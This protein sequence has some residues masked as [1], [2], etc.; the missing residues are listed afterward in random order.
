MNTSEHARKSSLVFIFDS[1]AE[2]QKFRAL[3]IV[4]DFSREALA[5]VPDFSV[6]G[7]RVVRELDRLVSLRGRILLIVSEKDAKLERFS[8]DYMGQPQWANQ[9]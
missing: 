9:P 5:V 8:G 6:P 1:P 7:V 2:G 4:D 3:C